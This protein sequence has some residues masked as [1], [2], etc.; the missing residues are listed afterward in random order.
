MTCASVAP[1]PWGGAQ[2]FDIT[3]PK[4]RGMCWSLLG[5]ALHLTAGRPERITIR[6]G[7]VDLDRLRG[8]GADHALAALRA[9]GV[10]VDTLRDYAPRAMDSRGSCGE[11]YFAEVG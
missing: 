3:I 6:D 2:R 9:A 7:V 11:D 10:R 5:R 8:E 1:C 4:W